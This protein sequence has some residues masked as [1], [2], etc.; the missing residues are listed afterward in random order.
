M[1][2]SSLI[3]KIKCIIFNLEELI[4]IT[5]AKEGLKELELS[6][7]VLSDSSKANIEEVLSKAGLTS[8]F[9]AQHIFSESGSFP[10]AAKS[11]GLQFSE[12]AI[13]DTHEVGMELAKKGDFWIFERRNGTDKEGFENKGGLLFN[14]FDELRELID[15]FNAEVDLETEKP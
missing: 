7:L 1:K 6:Y 8:F 10:D 12:C 11:F 2:N 15:L 4:Q 5:G 13:V 3:S 9:T 14:D